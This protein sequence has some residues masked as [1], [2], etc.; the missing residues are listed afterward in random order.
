MPF[1]IKDGILLLAG[2]LIKRTA[3]MR[4]LNISMASSLSDIP[5]GMVFQSVLFSLSS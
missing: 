5:R 1:T 2:D 4:M 3:I